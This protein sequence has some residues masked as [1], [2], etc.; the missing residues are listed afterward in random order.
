MAL[1]DQPEGNGTGFVWD[2]DGH[3]VTNYHVLGGAL[4]SLGNTPPNGSQNVARVTLLSKL[5]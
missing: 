2:S 5:H 4:Q 1:A 3:I